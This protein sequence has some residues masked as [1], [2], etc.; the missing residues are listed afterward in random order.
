MAEKNAR[1]IRPAWKLGVCVWGWCVATRSRRR[2]EHPPGRL[3]IVAITRLAHPARQAYREACPMIR[4][5]VRG[6]R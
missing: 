4:Y 1:Q 5:F 2:G 3:A 6:P